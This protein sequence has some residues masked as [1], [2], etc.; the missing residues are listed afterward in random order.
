[1]K[2]IK[3]SVHDHI[4]L[5]PVAADLVD[6]PAFQRLRHIKQLSTVRLVYPSASHTRFEHSLGVYHLADRALSHL[7]VDDDAAAH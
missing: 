3:D 6:T 4:T 7:A 1:M 5:D 2:A